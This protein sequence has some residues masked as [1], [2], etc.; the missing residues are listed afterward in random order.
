M[1]HLGTDFPCSYGKVSGADHI[2][3]KCDILICLTCI[4]SC[5]CR[6]VYD[7]IGFF[8]FDHVHDIFDVC[9]IKLINIRIDKFNTV[10]I[11]IKSVYLSSKLSVTAGNE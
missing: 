11:G 10:L 7:G 3:L 1:N 2:Y 8:A 5:I 9:Y 4:N 6:T